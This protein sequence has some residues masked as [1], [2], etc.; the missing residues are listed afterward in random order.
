MTVS[1]GKIDLRKNKDFSTMSKDQLIKEI[2]LLSEEIKEMKGDKEYFEKDLEYIVN[3]AITWLKDNKKG[4][5]YHLYI[6]NGKS[7]LI[8]SKIE[9]YWI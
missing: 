1:K 5:K 3:L 6:K 8:K 7:K 2:H 4:K 9:D